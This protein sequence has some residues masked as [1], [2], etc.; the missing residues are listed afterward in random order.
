[1]REN[2]RGRLTLADL[3]DYACMTG[4]PVE[5]AW[6]VSRVPFSPQAARLSAELAANVYDLDIRAWARA[7]W[8]D[9]MFLVEDDV[10]PLDQES[11]TKLA[12]LENEWRRRRARSRIH[13]VSPISDLARAAR[14]LMVTDMSKSVVMTRA[15]PD[16][17]V[18]IAIAFIA[19]RPRFTT[20]SA[21]SRFS[22]KTASTTVFWSWPAAST[23]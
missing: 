2:T 13:G 8:N 15:L 21:T 4:E 11:D 1:M 10:I 9:C 20:G 18:L 19:L 5:D 14:Q 12:A 17:R 3:T 6:G 22:R 16:G 23:R 7:G